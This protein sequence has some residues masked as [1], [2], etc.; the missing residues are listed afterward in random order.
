M[1]HHHHHRRLGEKATEGHHRQLLS[2]SSTTIGLAVLLLLASVVV[3]APQSSPTAAASNNNSNNNIITI[4]LV[5]HRV[6]QQRRLQQS[7]DGAGRPSSPKMERPK[8]SKY[9]RRFLADQ[10]A[11]PKTAEQVAGLYQ[12]YGTVRRRHGTPPLCSQTHP[13]TNVFCTA[14]RRLVVRQSNAATTNG[15]CRHGVGRNRFSLQ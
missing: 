1:N 3:G 6:V 8:Y 13:I 11:A 2:H 14:L 9:D 7:R 15:D 12:G 4:P 10:A 5:P